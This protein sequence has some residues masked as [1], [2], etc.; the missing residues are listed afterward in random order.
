MWTRLW[1]WLTRRSFATLGARGEAAAAQFLRRQGCVIVA[2]HVQT[3]YGEL[4]LV[5]IDRGVVVFVE[6]KTR[7]SRLDG[8][9]VQAVDER[10]QRRMTRAALAFLRRHRLLEY[11]VRFDVVG[12]H[13][14]R[15]ARRPVIDHI[16]HAFEATGWESFFS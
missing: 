10:K 13:W 5:A 15:T 7:Q 2:R 16:R 11:P 12:I 3:G 8:P 1:G 6:V 14:P 9:A 4:D